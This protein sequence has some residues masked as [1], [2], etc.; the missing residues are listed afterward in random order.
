MIKDM[1]S[2]YGKLCAW[3]YDLDKPIPPQDA[4][5]FYLSY[6]DVNMSILEPMCG[7][8]RFLVP[9]AEKG[10]FIDGF[11]VSAEM[12]KRCKEKMKNAK[13]N[14]IL[15]HCDFLEYTPEKYYDFVFITSCSFSLITEEAM[16]KSYLNH[17]KGLTS[18]NGKIVLELLTA[19]AMSRQSDNEKVVEENNIEIVLSQNKI[20]IDDVKNIVYSVLKYE[21]YE[22]KRL[23]ETEEQNFNIKYYQSNEFEMYLKEIGM[24]LENKYIDYRKIRY[25]GQRTE[26]LIYELSS[27]NC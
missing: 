8:G 26:M 15:R 27:N 2:N 21:L 24:K 11:D 3:F 16:A 5:D 14:H 18:P 1:N 20:R 7:S 6:T 10:Y 12:L 19:D 17:L 13:N 9:F 25:N 23:M 22:N 4:M